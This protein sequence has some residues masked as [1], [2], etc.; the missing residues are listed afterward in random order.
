MATGG[1]GSAAKAIGSA[2]ALA[3]SAELAAAGSGVVTAAA[4]S[5]EGVADT[6][7]SAAAADDDT[8]AGELTGCALA[9]SCWSSGSCAGRA[10]PYT[11]HAC[12][13]MSTSRGNAEHAISPRASRLVAMAG[14]PASCSTR[15]AAQHLAAVG[16]LQR[17]GTPTFTRLNSQCQCRSMSH[18]FN[19]CPPHPEDGSHLH[20]GCRSLQ[21][22]QVCARSF[23][24]ACSRTRHGQ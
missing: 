9:P 12:C 1:N 6:I 14:L 20:A 24:V 15:G 16:V 22:R 11:S 13:T 10:R 18:I 17:D 21:R 2:L 23:E 7:T 19:L 4:A 3:T 5:T 8:P